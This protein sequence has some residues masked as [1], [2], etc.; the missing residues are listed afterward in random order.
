MHFPLWYLS[1]SLG[2][3]LVMSGC[4]LYLIF[5]FSSWV[6]LLD[7]FVFTIWN[8][9]IENARNGKKYLIKN[10]NKRFPWD[11]N[12]DFILFNFWKITWGEAEMKD[13]KLRVLPISLSWCW[14]L[15]AE[16]G[17]WY[18]IYPDYQPDNLLTIMDRAKTSIHLTGLSLS[19]S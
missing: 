9:I 5:H 16:E 12:W 3:V 10:E 15:K 13:E 11:S 4:C 1:S 17:N 19:L 2:V 18:H 6:K 14:W 8:R 7:L